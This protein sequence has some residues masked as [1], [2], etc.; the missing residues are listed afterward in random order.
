MPLST[1][2]TILSMFNFSNVLGMFGGAASSAAGAMNPLAM[3]KAQAAKAG[4]NPAMFDEIAAEMKEIAAKNLPQDQMMQA[5]HE[6]F[7]ERGFPAGA[8]D[9]A[10]AMATKQ[11]Q[12]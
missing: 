12:K 2:G 8:V 9:Q 1:Y 4:L 11:L 3:I 7:T 6:V 10:L 5:M